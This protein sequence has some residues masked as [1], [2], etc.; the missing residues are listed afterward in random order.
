MSLRLHQRFMDVQGQLLEDIV[1]YLLQHRIPISVGDGRLTDRETVS[2]N[3]Q[4][5]VA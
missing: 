2:N 4:S 3:R 1:N 5:V